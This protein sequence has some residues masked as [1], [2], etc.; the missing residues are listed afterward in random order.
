MVEDSSGRVLPIYNSLDSSFTPTQKA[1]VNGVL[2]QAP[3][4]LNFLSGL[5]GTYPYD[6]IGAVVDRTTGVGYAL[7]V[8]T[9]PHYAQLNS[10]GSISRFTQLHEIAHQWVGNA[11]TLETWLDIWFNEGWATWSEWAWDF[12]ENGGP[13]PEDVFADLYET[14]PDDFWT[15]APADL[16]GDPANLF[17]G[18]VYDR[19][20]MVVEGTRQILGE[21]GFA[22]LI[23]RLM[24]DFR[25]ANISTAEF[26]ELAKDVSGFSGSQLSLLDQFYEQ[27]LYGETRPTILP[28]AFGGASSASAG[29]SAQPRS[30]SPAPTQ[31]GSHSHR[32]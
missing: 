6:S 2:A 15:L 9:K 28:A 17:S 23:R 1:N 32:R 19:G 8:A 7:E 3:G 4:M 12:S 30:G 26:I 16:D 27:W 18:V 31:P 21:D 13:P 25:Y 5:Y 14:L 22:E 24:S 29:E 20:A 10:S 11:V